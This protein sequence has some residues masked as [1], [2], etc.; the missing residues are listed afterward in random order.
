VAALA[1]AQAAAAVLLA[2]LVAGLRRAP[3]PLDGS[4]PPLG[5]ASGSRTSRRPAAAFW[6]QL[7]PPS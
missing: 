6:S 4:T 7:V 3:L 5:P 1:A 2:A